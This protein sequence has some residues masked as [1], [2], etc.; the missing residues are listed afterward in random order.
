MAA[1]EVHN[2]HTGLTGRAKEELAQY[3]YN[4]TQS[5]KRG[6]PFHHTLE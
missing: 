4:A 5:S 2:G 1:K 6:A 3:Y